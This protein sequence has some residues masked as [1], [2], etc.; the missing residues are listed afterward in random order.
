VGK[1]ISDLLHQ[2]FQ[3]LPRGAYVNS[4]IKVTMGKRIMRQ[5][6]GLSMK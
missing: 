1:L 2:L 3:T 5:F 4:P 6:K